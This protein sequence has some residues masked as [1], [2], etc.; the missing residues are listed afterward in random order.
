MLKCQGLSSRATGAI[1]CALLACL[2]VSPIAHAQRP[3]GEVRIEVKDPS[4]AAVA[5]SGKLENIA[6]GTVQ[7]FQTDAQGAHSF[8]G[9]PFGRYRLE[10]TASG[11]ATQSVAWMSSPLTPVSKTVTLALSAQAFQ[12]DVVGAT[13]LAGTDLSPVEIPLPVQAGN[14]RDIRN[15][16]A[17]DLSDFL[18]KRLSGVYVNEIQGNPYQPDLNYRGYTASPLLGTPQGVSVY[19]DGVRLNQP[20]GDVVSWDLIPKIAIAEMALMPGSNPLIWSQHPG[21]RPI[22]SDQRWTRRKPHG[23]QL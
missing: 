9:L 5:A 23:N 4:G 1:W 8:A 13:P 6:S 17:L 3:A 14:Q 19:M 7:R 11:F 21:R 15:S 16:G 18:N 20:F 22:P 10:V 2:A 12:V